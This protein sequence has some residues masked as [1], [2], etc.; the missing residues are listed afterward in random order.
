MARPTSFIDRHVAAA[1]RRRSIGHRRHRRR[2]RIHRRQYR[3]RVVGHGGVAGGRRSPATSARNGAFTFA[4]K[5]PSGAGYNFDRR[6]QPGWEPSTVSGGTGTVASKECHERRRHLQVEHVFDRWW[7]R[8]PGCRG[9]SCCRTTVADDS[10]RRRERRVLVRDEAPAGTAYNVP[11]RPAPPARPARSPTAA[12]RW[13]SANVTN[14]AVTCTTDTYSIG[15][16]VSGLSGTV[17]LQDNGGDDLSVSANGG[18]TFATKLPPA[19]P[20]T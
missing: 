17:V 3:L 16:S 15:G 18:F 8:S 4:T 20:T 13:R 6:D 1:R 7:G 12:A 2:R 10:A 19:P 9:R 5:P 14:V 11:S